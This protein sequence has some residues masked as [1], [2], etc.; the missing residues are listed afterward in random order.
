MCFAALTKSLRAQTIFSLLL[1]SDNYTLITDFPLLKEVEVELVSLLDVII[2]CISIK[3]Q[4][5]GEISEV[6]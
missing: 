3:R 6:L 4:E 1:S 2:H 5:N